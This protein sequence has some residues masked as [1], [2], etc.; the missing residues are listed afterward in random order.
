MTRYIK[1]EQ[2]LHHSVIYTND[3]GKYFRHSDGKWTWRN[4]NPGNLV[5]GRI[6][7]KHGQIGVAGG[8]AVFPNREVGHEAL[9]ERQKY[10][11]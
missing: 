8:F 2:G 1:A 4:H 6:S 7:E 5:P 3:D 11:V 9:L 10:C